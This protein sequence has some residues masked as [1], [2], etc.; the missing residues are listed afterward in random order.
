M[1]V[2]CSFQLGLDHMHLFHWSAIMVV[3]QHL[4]ILCVSVTHLVYNRSSQVVCPLKGNA[5]TE[6]MMRTMGEELVWSNDWQF[7]MN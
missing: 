2:S 1:R 6:R 7:T 5:D 4:N 3:S